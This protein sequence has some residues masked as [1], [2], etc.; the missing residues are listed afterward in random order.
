MTRA[1]QWLRRRSNRAE[2]TR[3][4][5][6]KDPVP[7]LRAAAL[8]ITGHTPSGSLNLRAGSRRGGPGAMV[9]TRPAPGSARRR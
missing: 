5:Q 7:I 9:V 1:T 8:P 4:L 2:E 6:E 3:V